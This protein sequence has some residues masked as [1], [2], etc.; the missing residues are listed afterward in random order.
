M[1]NIALVID[2][3]G[4]GG[5]QKQICTLAVGLKKHGYNVCVLYYHD[6]DFF[7]SFLDINDVKHE[8]VPRA[9][10]KI[11]STISLVSN[12]VRKIR[13]DNITN[14][15]AFLEGP[16]L[17]TEL[18]RLVYPFFKLIVSERFMTVGEL[19]LRAKFLGG[20]HR[21]ASSVTVN[22]QSQFIRMQNDFPFLQESLFCIYNG[23]STPGYKEPVRQGSDICRFLVVSS[24]AAKKNPVNLV[25][26]AA[27]LKN[28]GFRFRITWA[29]ST[30]ISTTGT[31]VFD[32]CQRLIEKF[33]LE[34]YFSFIGEV[35]DVIQLYN[36]SDW[37]VHPSF[38]EGL[39]NAICEA[40]SV[41]LPVLASDVCDHPYLIDNS[42]GMLFDPNSVDSI[43]SVLISAIEV[44]EDKF[45][46]FSLN[47]RKY[48]EDKLAVNYMVEKYLKLLEGDR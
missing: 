17:Y 14:V 25:M 16:A 28:S 40:L 36:S 46:T 34:E 43:A 30:F 33:G 5:A 42:R 18:S 44:D 35:R 32:E 45:R 2:G 15:I 38:Y 22:S 37:L 4:S 7:K 12:L 31:S 27:K 47:C 21:L 6:E 1:K 41:G 19:S 9:N 24:V 13:R 48:F 20:M 10:S 39:P 26:A 29:G 23:Y 11:L 3:L 8:L